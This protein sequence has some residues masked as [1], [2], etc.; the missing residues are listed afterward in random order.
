M[1]SFDSKIALGTVCTLTVVSQSDSLDGVNLLSKLWQIIFQFERQFSRF[2]PDSELS[3]F[4]RL[5]GSKVYISPMFEAL[6]KKTKYFAT[7]TNG[8]YNPFILPILSRIGYDHSLVPGYENDYVDDYKLKQV[9]EA[10]KLK[11][12]NSQAQIPYG[13]A[14]DL[15]G[16]GKGFLLDHLAD[17]M[18]SQDDIKGYWFSLGG[19][20]IAYGVDDNNHPWEIAIQ[21]S[22]PD[23]SE[24]E[25]GS[26]N[27][28]LKHQTLAIATS[29][30]IAR[31]GIKDNI[32]WHHLID[33]RIN[34]PARTDI[35]LATIVS[36]SAIFSDV[37]ASCLVL[38]GRSE[39]AKFIKHHHIANVL[40]QGYSKKGKFIYKVFGNRIKIGSK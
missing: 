17:F 38:V 1:L 2:L 4:N 28:T 19:D 16:C 32:K 36:D 3:R 22:M 35:D 20:I 30:T 18:K 21:K 14:I 37:M 13:T 7:L 23:Y 10:R 9:V 40:I 5:A 29:G 11:I 25:I 33:P 34:A 26:I 27:L 39:S 24:A 6:L 12:V 8:L 31:K 15:G